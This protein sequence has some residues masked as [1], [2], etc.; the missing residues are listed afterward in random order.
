MCA[1]SI[2][3]SITQQVS[4]VTFCSYFAPFTFSDINE[5]SSSPCLNGGTCT[6]G[7]NSFSCECY[8]GYTGKN[9]ETGKHSC[10][11]ISTK[12]QAQIFLVFCSDVVQIWKYFPLES[13]NYETEQMQVNRHF[14]NFLQCPRFPIEVDNEIVMH[15]LLPLEPLFVFKPLFV[16]IEATDLKNRTGSSNS[17]L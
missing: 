12:I 1:F 13:L 17:L 3:N 14:R 5:C 11:I 7:I 15:L 9:C 8:P 16:F 4:L 6:D 2:V 10:C